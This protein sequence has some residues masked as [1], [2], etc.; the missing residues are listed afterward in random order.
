MNFA[1]QHV[2]SQTFVTSSV[3]DSKDSRCLFQLLSQAAGFS[4]AHVQQQVTGNLHVKI[5]LR[6][7]GPGCSPGTL[8]LTLG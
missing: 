4:A 2:A 3:P 5:K 7:E 6:A 1:M 8:P